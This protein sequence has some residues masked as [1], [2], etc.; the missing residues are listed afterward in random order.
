MCTSIAKRISISFFD[1][2]V[3]GSKLLAL[4]DDFP[5]DR[6]ILR[7]QQFYIRVDEGAKYEIELNVSSKRNRI[8]NVR[9]RTVLKSQT[10]RY[11]NK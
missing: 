6:R 2:N 9:N 4:V 7:F 11:T 5:S 10:F 1:A 8:K 3:H